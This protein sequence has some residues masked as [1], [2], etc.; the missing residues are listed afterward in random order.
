[1]ACPTGRRLADWADPARRMDSVVRAGSCRFDAEHQGAAAMRV[2]PRMLLALPVFFGLVTGLKAQ[3]MAEMAQTAEYVASLQNPD[4]GFGAGPGQKSNLNATSSGIR[5]LKYNAGAIKDPLG[6]IA[7]VQSCFDEKSGGFSEQ[8]G[9]TPGVAITALGLMAVAELKLDTKPFADKAIGFFHEKVKTFEDLRIAAA[10]LEA[11]GRKSDDFPKWIEQVE[12]EMN[13]DGTFGSGGEAQRATGGRVAALL[14]M[15]V[16]LPDD[17]KADV[18]KL[19]RDGQMPDG[20]WSPDGKASNLD[21]TYRIMRC[22]YMLKAAPNLTKLRAFILQ[23]RRSDGSYAMTPFG[24]DKAGTYIC[25]IVL[26]WAR[27]LGGQPAF[28]ETAGFTSLFNGKDLTGWEGNKDIWKVVNNR[29]VGDSPGIKQN[30]FLA[31]TADYENFVLKLTFRLKGDESANSG[32]QFRSVR[33]PGTEMSGYQADIGKGY[34]GSLYDESRRNKV[35]VQGNPKAVENVHHERWNHYVIRA[36]GNEITLTLNGV[37]SVTYREVDPKIARSGK[38]ALQVHAGKPLQIEFKDLWIQ[39]LPSPT[40]TEE[41]KPGFTVR[42]VK[43]PDGPRKY[44][45]YL[46]EGF[47]SAKTYPLVLFLH[48][49]GERGEDG[50]KQSQVGLGPAILKSPKSFPAIAVFAQAKKGWGAGTDDAKAALAAVEEVRKLAKV[51]PARISLTGLSMGGFGSWELA[52]AHPEMWSAVAP[53]CGRGKPEY[54]SNIKGLP[55]WTLVGDDDGVQTVR[56]TRDMFVAVQK[57]G[58][59]PRITEYLSVPHNSWDRA[60]NDPALIEWLI[61]SHR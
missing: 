10:G 20:G 2:V 17:R 40:P 49:S 23:H 39:P 57:A 50:V 61:N 14:R 13:A 16:E 48:G 3:T 43:G 58:G 51:D 25:S 29:I 24:D 11:V 52:N 18:V 44:T 55:I 6:A 34:W 33:I 21:S 60:Y 41:L 27:Q 9:G 46:P 54:A 1:M 35:L 59:K 5:M 42:T 12:S 37:N 47:D 32:V 22:L 36:M 8:P 15:G 53:I 38:I 26:Y 7:Y 19:L 28:V 45:L 31:T 4:G 56:N 30:E